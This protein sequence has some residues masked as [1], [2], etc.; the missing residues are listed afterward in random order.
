MIT[1][2]SLYIK[3]TVKVWEICILTGS[4]LHVNTTLASSLEHFSIQLTLCEVNVTVYLDLQLKWK[5]IYKIFVFSR[6]ALRWTSHIMFHRNIMAAVHSETQY[7]IQGVQFAHLYIWGEEKTTLM[8]RIKSCSL[9]NNTD[10]H[11]TQMNN[12]I[13]IL[14]ITLEE[15]K[16]IIITR[17]K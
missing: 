2:S 11:I 8:T 14:T 6:Q 16:D 7:P 17:H 4:Y 5:L 1:G 10:D 9:L 12:S 15:M 13:Y 3:N